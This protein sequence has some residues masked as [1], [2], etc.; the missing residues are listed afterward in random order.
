MMRKLK[1]YGD[2]AVFIGHKEFTIQA[3]DIPRVMSFLLNNFEGIEKYMNPR[4][5]Q[6]KVGNYTIDE[7]QL[8]DP[9][10]QEDIH[11][12]P[13][14]AGAGGGFGR[15]LLGI[16]LIGV[17]IVAPGAGLF[18]GGS[19]GFG[20]TTA[21][22]F[23]MAALAGNIGIALTLSGVAQM[24]S[25]TRED[26]TNNE[27]KSI[28]FGFNTIQNVSR[29]GLPVPIV[30]GEMVVGSLVISAGLDVEKVKA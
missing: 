4:Y 16:A 17:A 7:N 22:A 19:I 21:G 11:I 30:Y 25:P 5:Y 23:S 3:N 14:I 18:A 10:G 29:A 9:I 6:V 2:L 27:D 28:S 8:L 15:T 13:V 26:T 20:A 1:L 12:V 24:L